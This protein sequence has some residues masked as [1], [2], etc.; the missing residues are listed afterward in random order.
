MTQHTVSSLLTLC[1]CALHTSLARFLPAALLVSLRTCGEAF[2][3][4]MLL[5]ADDGAAASAL[6]AGLPPKKDAISF[7]PMPRGSLLPTK[8]RPCGF[9]KA[10]CLGNL[11]AAGSAQNL[12]HR[13]ADNASL[14]SAAS[15]DVRSLLNDKRLVGAA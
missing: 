6:A 14:E 12:L 5:P 3:D 4:L 15:L 9:A 1:Q 11:G 8:S 10:E 13:K 7:W 2:L